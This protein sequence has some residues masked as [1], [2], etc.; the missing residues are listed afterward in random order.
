[1]HSVHSDLDAETAMIYSYWNYGA[2]D[3]APPQKDW[4]LPLVKEKAP[5]LTRTCLGEKKNLGRDLKEIEARND[6]VGEGQ[7]QFKQQTDQEE[8]HR[9]MS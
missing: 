6:C 4:P 2:T 1:M 9:A 7:Q 8:I 3:V 5:F